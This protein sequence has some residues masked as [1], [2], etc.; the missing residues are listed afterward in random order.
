MDEKQLKNLQKLAR[1]ALTPEEEKKLLSNLK[2]ILSHID[3]L[4]E[5]DTEG[6]ETC[7]HVTTGSV[8]PLR[9]DEPKRLIEREEF[10][11]NAPDHI[12]GMIRVPKVIKDEL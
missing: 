5:V 11:K 9:E 8:A 4:N 12:G 7:R 1:I 3:Q 2:N 10:L 6:V